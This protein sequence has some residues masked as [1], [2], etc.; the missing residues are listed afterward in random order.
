MMT[1]ME[2]IQFK[3]T[4]T[5][6]PDSSATFVMIPYDILE[7]WGT[8]SRVP[9]KGTINGHTFRSTIAPYGGVHYLGIN[10]NLREAAG[11]KAGDI[12][13]IELEKDLEPRVLEVPPDFQ[14]ALD[15][16]PAARIRWQKLSFTHQRE[17]VESIED[18]KKPE[19]R[20]RRIQAAIDAITG[21]HK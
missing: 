20:I 19:T 1:M 9:V 13:D 6:E 4:L 5:R 18:A 17:Y 10:R 12:V 3:A 2:V 16:N 21:K 8:R 15:T 7:V 14:S 11:V